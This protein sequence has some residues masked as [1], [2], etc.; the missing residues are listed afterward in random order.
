MI[1]NCTLAGHTPRDVEMF[2]YGGDKQ[3]AKF[4]LAINKRIKKDG[5][6][7]D[8]TTWIRCTVFGN[9]AKWLDG[10]P[11][12][13]LIAVSGEMYQE[14]WEKDGQKNKTL[15][16]DCRSA[17]WMNKPKGHQAPPAPSR[18]DYSDDS[19]VPF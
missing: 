16:I 12:G 9:D 8:H 4:T 10:A 11:K 18:V 2:N 17:R 3:G 7:C 19:E 14:E 15:C 13:A 1:N 6:W 5:E